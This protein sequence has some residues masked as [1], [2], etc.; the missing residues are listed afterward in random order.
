MSLLASFLWATYAFGAFGT[1]VVITMAVSHSGNRR[2]W[3]KVPA[4][5]LAWPF[6]LLI[7]IAQLRR[8][9][10]QSPSA[11][12]ADRAAYRGHGACGEAA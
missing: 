6:V 11:P 3:W 10:A 2:S 8:K 1:F 5:T 4:Y 12:S 7:G 9:A